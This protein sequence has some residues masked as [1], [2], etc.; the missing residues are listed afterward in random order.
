MSN[1]YRTRK[2]PHL[3]L[4]DQQFHFPLRLTLNPS[5][6]QH[7]PSSG[8]GALGYYLQAIHLFATSLGQVAYRRIAFPPTDVI[9][10][11]HINAPSPPTLVRL[12]LYITYM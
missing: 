11:H 9:A 2:S 1:I 5:T 10:K 7:P 8:T 12:F 4:G 3:F 6:D